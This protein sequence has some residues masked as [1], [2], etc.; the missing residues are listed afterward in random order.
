LGAGYNFNWGGLSVIPY[1]QAAGIATELDRFREKSDSD[2]GLTMGRQHRDSVT[3]TVGTELNYAWSTPYGVFLPRVFGEWVHE[4]R[5]SSRSITS[6]LGRN[7]FVTSFVT[8]DPIRNWGNVGFGAQL[9]MPNAI[10][11][12]VNYSSLIIQGA[13]NHTVEGG[14]RWD[15]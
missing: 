12:F 4:Y 2:V 14:V 6:T 15:F 5:N 13:T 7:G 1:F 11:A 9:V 8:P 3:T 10:S